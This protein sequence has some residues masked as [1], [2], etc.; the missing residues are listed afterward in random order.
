MDSYLL[1]MSIGD[2]VKHSGYVAKGVLVTLMI[3]SILSWSVIL[4]RYLNY[5]RYMKRA[6]AFYDKMKHSK[7]VNEILTFAKSYPD[8]PLKEMFLET[9]RELHEQVTTPAPNPQADSIATIRYEDN[10]ERTLQRVMRG[11]TMHLE[12]GLAFLA[13]TAS[14]TPFIGLFGTVWGIMEAF[15]A[16]GESG[17]ATLASV[18]P[19]ISEALITTAAGLFAAIPALIGYNLLGR[20]IKAFGSYMEQFGLDLINLFIKK[21]S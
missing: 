11:Q 12:S 1:A 6:R 15:R 14:V 7:G 13:T 16:I 17:S 19:G 18:A 8:N 5:R 9:Y 4:D 2:L 10:L 3:F 21:F 20:K